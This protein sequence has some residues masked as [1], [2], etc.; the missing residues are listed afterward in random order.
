MKYYVGLDLSLVATGLIVLDSEANIVVKRLIKVK[1]RGAQRLSEIRCAILEGL[2][3]VALSNESY[4]VNIEGYS[5]GSKNRGLPFQIGELGGVVKAC[6]YD[7]KM[8]FIVTAP[9]IMKKFVTGRGNAKKEEVIEAISEIWGEEF[10][11]NNLA[12]AYGLARMALEVNK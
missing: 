7:N 9:M 6:L 11:D 4:I 2:S 1:S 10:K 5:Y 8:E 3:V 12:D